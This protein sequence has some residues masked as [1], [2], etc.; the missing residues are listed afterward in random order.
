MVG[1]R[2]VGDG[3]TRIT[4]LNGIREAESG[5]LTFLMDRR[6]FPYF[7]ETQAAAVLVPENFDGA[8]R[9]VIHVANPYLS[10]TSLLERQ[11]ADS[12]QHPHGIH[13]SAVVNE[14][15]TLGKNVTLDAHVTIEADCAIGDDVV[16][17]AGV[18]VGRGTTIGAGTVIYPNVTIRDHTEIGARCTIHANTA[19]GSDGFGF[20]PVNGSLKKI[21]QVGRVI[22]GDEVEI[23]SNTAID[24]AMCGETV[25][26]TGTK[27][28]NLVQVGHNVRIGKHCTISGST[29][30]SGS[31]RIGDYVTIGGQVGINGHVEIGDRVVIAARSGVTKSIPSNRVVSG[32]PAEDHALSKRIMSSQRNVPALQRRVRQLEK[33]LEEVLRHIHGKTTDDA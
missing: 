13:P 29:G 21:P 10:F 26:G 22:I 15:A 20:L 31:A 6:Y 27:I 32:F 2:V 25:I 11:R 4:G 14:S 7:S 9:P 16:I 33:Q 12:F 18:Y 8:G 24:R 30:I 1:G 23:G 5:D 17:Y 19:I 28:D 3:I